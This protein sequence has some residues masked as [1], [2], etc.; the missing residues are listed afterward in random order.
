MLDKIIGKLSSKELFEDDLRKSYPLTFTKLYRLHGR[1]YFI[2]M[3]TPER[4]ARAI[5]KRH[6]CLLTLDPEACEGSRDGLQR[7]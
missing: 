3:I 6:F 4:E 2:L 7:M 1:F 5:T